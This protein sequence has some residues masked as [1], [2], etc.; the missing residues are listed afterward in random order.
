MGANTR[1]YMLVTAVA[2]AVTYCTF[3]MQYTTP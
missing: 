1:E 3:D 2:G